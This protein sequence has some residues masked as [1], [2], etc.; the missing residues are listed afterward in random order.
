MDDMPEMDAP[1]GDVEVVTRT[2]AYDMNFDV[3]QFLKVMH[4]VMFSP[5]DNFD[6]LTKIAQLDPTTDY[7]NADLRGVN[8]EGSDLT[9]YNLSC[10]D[11]RGCIGLPSD[12]EA[13]RIGLVLE[14]AKR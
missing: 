3:D 1:E 11:L 4:D 12:E 10:A 13:A 9:G 8:F 2:M 5:F 7:I 14:G 6:Q